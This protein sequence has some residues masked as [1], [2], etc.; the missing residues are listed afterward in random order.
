[1]PTE[2]AVF[3]PQALVSF[4]PLF[5]TIRWRFRAVQVVRP[6]RMLSLEI[7][8]G[9]PEKQRCTKMEGRQDGRTA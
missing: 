3:R 4:S 1:M 5:S 2:A 8:A 6:E 7:E 9:D